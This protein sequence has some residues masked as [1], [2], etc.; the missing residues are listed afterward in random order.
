MT[1]SKPLPGLVKTDGKPE[2]VA[3]LGVEQ[4]NSGIGIVVLN[5]S[6]Q[7]YTM[8]PGSVKVQI[9]RELRECIAEAELQKP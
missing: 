1:F 9:D 8:P 4:F 5:G 7:V 2:P 6:G 3:V